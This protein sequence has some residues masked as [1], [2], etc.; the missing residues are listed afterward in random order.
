MKTNFILVLSI[1][2]LLTTL[3]LVVNL[4]EEKETSVVNDDYL[5]QQVKIDIQQKEQTSRVVSDYEAKGVLLSGQ[6]S[7]E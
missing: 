2:L 3:T 1:V 5:L 4:N 7:L 6:C